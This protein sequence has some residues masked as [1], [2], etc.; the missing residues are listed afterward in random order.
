M[1]EL[2]KSEVSLVSGAANYDT[3]DAGCFLQISIL[4]CRRLVVQ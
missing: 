2:S 3:L 4:G 1:R